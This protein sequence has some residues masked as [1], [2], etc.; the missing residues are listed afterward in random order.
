[1]KE[2]CNAEEFPY[3]V[4]IYH[5]KKENS[6]NQ[7]FLRDYHLLGT[8]RKSSSNSSSFI[9]YPSTSVKFCFVC[10]DNYIFNSSYLTDLYNF[11]TNFL[12]KIVPVNL[13]FGTT[14]FPLHKFECYFVY[15]VIGNH[16]YLLQFHVQT[17]KLLCLIDFQ[18]LQLLPLH[19]ID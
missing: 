8:F 3:N 6:V 7:N 11:H 9:Y 1:M 19:L 5:M 12:S 2:I 15:S 10:I 16:Q 17:N 13:S 4:K 14:K 18:N